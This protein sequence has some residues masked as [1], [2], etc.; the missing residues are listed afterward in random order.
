MNL[1]EKLLNYGKGKAYPFHM[2]GH[3]RNRDFCSNLFPYEID[4]TEIAEFDNLHHAEGILKDAMEKASALWGSKESFF[5]INGSS[6]GLLAAI[7]AVTQFGDG[8]LLSRGCH[9]AVYHGIE[10][11]GLHARYC[12]PPLLQDIPI[13]GSFS[14]QT[15][16][17]ELE[18]FPECRLVIL[19]SPTYEGVVS[20]IRQIAQIVH[21]AGCLLLVDEA[22][23]AH[24][25]FSDGFPDTAVHLGADLVIQS[26]HKT[27][28]S[29][30][31]TA[32]LHICSDRVDRDEMRRQLS[33]FQSS[34]P[35]Y[36][37]LAEIDACVS[38]LQRQ[39]KMLF[40]AYERRLDW[41]EEKL[42]SMQRF[43]HYL[44]KKGEQVFDFDRGKVLLFTGNTNQSGVTLL[45]TLREKYDLELEMAQPA[46]ALAMTSIL[47]TDEG[48]RRLAEAMQELDAQ[49]KSGTMIR[50]TA[51]FR[52]PE[53]V[54]DSAA[55]LQCPWERITLAASRDRIAADYM[56]AYPPGIPLIVPG[57]RIS[58]EFLQE[59]QMLQQTGVN[60]QCAY[61]KTGE[62]RVCAKD[63]EV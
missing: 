47:D 11:C 8:V 29:P 62:I 49:A 30:T 34:S 54:L 7:R 51:L 4:I 23:G 10:L 43:S 55:A 2:P 33:V 18:S 50:H 38:L 48:M 42:S 57:E 20:D 14:P 56:W 41:L 44:P 58:S 25:G 59:V 17:Q 32:I 6:G 53:T 35:S 28:P 16:R 13:L 27:L 37:F 21:A 61:G 24:L 63:M 31:Q 52:L 40:D 26:L 19:T 60:V 5:L 3:K 36:V 1:R 9:R 22:H 12:L 15:V 46:Y 45:Q 39:G